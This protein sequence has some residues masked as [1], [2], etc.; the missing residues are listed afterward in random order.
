MLRSMSK[1]NQDNFLDSKG[2][3]AVFNNLLPNVS[4]DAENTTPFLLLLDRIFKI[5]R[6]LQA[7]YCV[8]YQSNTA[9]TCV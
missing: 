9:T 5:F 8:R 3:A 4:W 2:I 7:E 1:S 6:K